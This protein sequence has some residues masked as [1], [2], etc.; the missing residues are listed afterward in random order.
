MKD[1]LLTIAFL[2]PLLTQLAFGCKCQVS[3]S[4]CDE[5]ASSNVVFIG[6]VESIEPQF[7]NR[8]NLTNA[9]SLNSLNEAFINAQRHPSKITLDHL[10]DIY[11]KTLPDLLGDEK[12]QAADAKT[13]L[14]VT[15][16]FNAALARGMRVRF[17]VRTLFKHQDDD[18]DDDKDDK[19]ADAKKDGEKRDAEKKDPKPKDSDDDVESELDVWNPFG[20]C[21]FDFQTGETYLVYANTE[22][23]SDY[24]FTGSCTRTRRLSDAGEDLGYL[25]FYKNDRERSARLEGFTTSDANSQ[26]DFDN[27]HEP[28]SLKLPV[29]DALI[30]LRSDALVRYTQPDSNGRFFFDGLPK[31]DYRISAYASGYPLHRQLLA[32]GRPLQITGKSCARQVL[33]LSTGENK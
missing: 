18:D 2:G 5:V 4:S 15:S 31:G 10:K 16:S 8:W 14:E 26:S 9:S 12:N 24:I 28:T 11:L 13:T 33:L 25:F 32:P 23:A 29:A 20:D 30:E 17:R 3:R 27:L 7:L 21:G 1:K 22:E 19:K 6:T